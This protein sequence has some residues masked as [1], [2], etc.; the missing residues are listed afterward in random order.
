MA[1]IFPR[2]A[3]GKQMNGKIELFKQQNFVGNEC[4]GNA[5]I[6]FQNH[7]QNRYPGSMVMKITHNVALE[8]H[9]IL[10][11]LYQTNKEIFEGIKLGSLFKSNQAKESMN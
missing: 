7:P 10:F 1:E 3:H 6:A 8:I 5:G 4:F 11:S 2:I 9:P